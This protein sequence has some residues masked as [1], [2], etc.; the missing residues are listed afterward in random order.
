MTPDDQWPQVSRTLAQ[1]QSIIRVRVS[2]EADIATA[3]LSLANAA[4]VLPQTDSVAAGGSGSS[5]DYDDA[6]AATPTATSTVDLSD[7]DAA[8]AF[9]WDEASAADVAG[10]V[11][12]RAVERPRPGAT[13]ASSGAGEQSSRDTQSSRAAVADVARPGGRRRVDEISRG[14]LIEGSTG[15]SPT[16]PDG[17]PGEVS[18]AVGGGAGADM[19]AADGVGA[20][21]DGSEEAVARLRRQ[22]GWF[23]WRVAH[24]PLTH[25][26]AAALDELLMRQTLE[27]AK[28]AHYGG[29]S[30]ATALHSAQHS[31]APP[32]NGCSRWCGICGM[33]F[34]RRLRMVPLRCVLGS[35]GPCCAVT[36]PPDI[37]MC[38]PRAGVAGVRLHHSFVSRTG[39]SACMQA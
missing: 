29:A 16:T 24:G 7:D 21:G 28:Q 19:W 34:C 38:R 5:S 22:V 26:E 35:A 39:G 30:P 14:T 27:L 20:A 9:E 36:C 12:G 23:A 10:E 17:L 37:R 18:A 32:G 31:A 15:S 8:V 25:D 2:Q 13:P 4:K 3:A 33:H 11:W 6:I 1:L